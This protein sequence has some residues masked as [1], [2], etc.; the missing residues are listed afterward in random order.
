MQN[1]YLL[2]FPAE[3]SGNLLTYDLVK[4]F[5]LKIN[6]LRASIEF[7]AKGFLLIDILSPMD[8]IEEAIEYIEQNGIE[9]IQIKAAIHVEEHKC[10]DCGACTAVCKVGALIL[11]KEA[12]LC[13]DNEK[14]ID[15]KACIS[16][17]PARA[18]SAVF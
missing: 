8:A 18:I 6:I 5:D 3:S 16:A 12:T 2:K 10:V 7:D 17:C 13:F 14:C 9:V 15:C 1:M 11:D 4:K